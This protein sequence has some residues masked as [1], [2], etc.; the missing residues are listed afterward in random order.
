MRIQVLEA[1]LPIF[2]YGKEG[3]EGS[4]LTPSEVLSY[5]TFLNNTFRNGYIWDLVSG[6]FFGQD[7]IL[8]TQGWVYEIEVLPA[9]Q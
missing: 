3:A 9:P 4:N 7:D 1:A 5:T 6:P 2:E 8:K